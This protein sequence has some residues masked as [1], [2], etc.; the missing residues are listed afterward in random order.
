MTNY[1]FKPRAQLLLQLGE[2]LIKNESVALIELIKNAYDADADIV[3]V[4]MNDIN[5]PM[6]GEIIIKDDGFGMSKDTIENI[7]LEPGNTHKKDMIK[8]GKRTPKGRLPIGEKGIGRFGVHKLGH[9]IILVT[10]AKNSPE[11]VVEMD[12]DKFVDAQ[13]L[14]DVNIK[15]IERHPEIFIGDKTGT[16]IIIKKLRQVWK[17]AAFK[18][19]CRAINNLNSP[20]EQKNR[21]EVKLSCNLEGWEND[22]IT[23]DKIKDYA[24]FHFTASINTIGQIS[25]EYNFRPFSEMKNIDSR[26]CV[27]M[28]IAVNSKNEN[29]VSLDEN[30]NPQCR[31]GDFTFEMF[32]FDRDAE[33]IKKFVLKDRKSFKEYLDE[34]GGIYV[35]REGLRIYDYGE[36]GNDWL[37][38]DIKRVNRPGETL[39]NNI[40]LGAVQ[41]KREESVDLIEKANREGFIENA[42]FETLKRLLERCIELF[43]AERNIDKEKYRSLKPT[44][45]PLL[46]ELAKLKE[47]IEKSNATD[48]EKKIMTKY[49]GIIDKEYDYIK[50]ITLTTASAG[51]TYGVVIHEIEK[52]IKEL[53]TE[54]HDNAE[55][56][57]VKD[58][59]M[60]LSDTIENYANLL[61]KRETSDNRLLSIAKRAT[62]NCAYRFKAHKLTCEIK[63]ETFINDTVNCS[64]NLI[65]GSIMNLFDNS[66]WWLEHAEREEKQI[67]V[68]LSRYLKGYKTLIIVDNGTGFTIAP[69]DAIKPF[70]S[71]KPGG[72][73]V[74]LNLINEIMDTH[75]GQLVFPSIDEVSDVDFGEFQPKAIVGLAFKE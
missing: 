75:N 16:L 9:E 36:K 67:K 25:Y 72:M 39:S 62:A 57:S 47:I 54:V 12:W 52:I 19:I 21:F 22:V 33:T 42:A 30:G 28:E 68:A 40:V 74:G 60:H 15:I 6:L 51:L 20:F 48:D 2:Q 63:D 37:Q 64:I 49:V 11:I 45:E 66:I 24:L 61:R 56:F 46:S 14:N 55:L 73:G 41:L 23:F 8:Q 43:L 4:E 53:V 58:K 26:F 44:Q 7:W 29:I 1:T 50:T 35:F 10:K 5:S 13:Y 38:L 27:G 34:N 59:I 18:Q 32:A 17:Y 65:I 69:E 31:I 70:V 3:E 71:K